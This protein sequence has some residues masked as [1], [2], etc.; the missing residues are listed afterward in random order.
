MDIKN[1]HLL[2]VQYFGPTD[3]KGQRLKVYSLRFLQGV[4]LPWDYSY[5]NG[6]EI[7]IDYLKENGFH[8][9]GTAEGGTKTDYIIVDT[10]EPLKS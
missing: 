9:I 3:H 6:L 2:K 1:Y 8:I 7:A 5:N 10:F 4:T